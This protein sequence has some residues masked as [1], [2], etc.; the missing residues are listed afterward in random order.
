MLPCLSN[1]WDF[2]RV[3]DAIKPTRA[4]SARTSQYRFDARAAPQGVAGS[5]SVET[6]RRNN[7]TRLG[8]SPKRPPPHGEAL[9]AAEHREAARDVTQHQRSRTARRLGQPEASVLPPQKRAERPRALGGRQLPE[10]RRRHNVRPARLSGAETTH[11]SI[12]A[13]MSESSSRSTTPPA[14]AL[15]GRRQPADARHPRV[16]QH[17]EGRAGPTAGRC[18]RAARSPSAPARCTP[19][20]RCASANQ[21]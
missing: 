9:D 11:V 16:A 7:H 21:R 20:A 18:W 15:D 5:G 2:E 6:H 10:R 13:A 19:S 17:E 4:F 12:D 3:V 14:P 1:E 8:G